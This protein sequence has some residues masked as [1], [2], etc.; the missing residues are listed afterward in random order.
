[1]SEINNC[2]VFNKKA[3]NIA[4]FLE[5][6]NTKILNKADIDNYGDNIEEEDPESP[7]YSL[8]FDCFEKHDEFV[9]KFKKIAKKYSIDFDC[10]VIIDWSFH[11]DYFHYTYRTKNDELKCY[12]ILPEHKE[13]VS[14]SENYEYE[15]LG[16]KYEDF[17]VPGILGVDM[18]LH[19]YG[20]EMD[21][22]LK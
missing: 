9:K 11:G 19:F 13:Q 10:T 21:K 18:I 20:D 16:K 1:M 5:E 17:D 4:E 6:I 22:L 15:F 8:Y 7:F 3:E 12:E 2:F 14:V